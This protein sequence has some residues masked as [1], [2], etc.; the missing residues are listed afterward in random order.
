MWQLLLGA[1]VAGST[2]LLAK[3]L[4]NPNPI[5]QDSSN[6]N[7]DTEKRDPRLQ[8]RFLESGCESNWD[9]TPKQGEI[10]RFSSSES[11]VRTKTG[12]KARKKVVLKK[13]EK[14][15]NGGS[16]VEVN[17]KKFSVCSKKR[18]TA[19]NEAY[20]CGAFPSKGMI[21]FIYQL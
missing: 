1:A 19:K 17:R 16:G 5:S 12:V 9:E 11:A 13:A 10:F 18:R 21:L 8:N 2:G 3:H 15:S 4:F 6:T 7:F 14:R 20:K